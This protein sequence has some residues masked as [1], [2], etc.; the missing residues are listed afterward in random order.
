MTPR[1]TIRRF[2][3]GVGSLAACLAVSLPLVAAEPIAWGEDGYAQSGDVRIHYVSGGAGPLVV[4]LHGFPDCWYTWRH[5]APA[6]A[7]SFQVVAIDQRGYNLSDQPEGVEQYS[8][9]RLVADVRAV[10]QHFGRDQA[11]IVGHDWGGAVAWAFA[12]AHPEMTDRLVILNLPHPH[13]LARELA[14]NEQQR[15]N[16]QYARSFQEPGAEDRLT[17]E[18][19]AA[20]VD[21][22]NDRAVYIAAFRRSSFA[23]M[24]NFYRANYPRPPYQI[25]STEPP[26]VA[27]PVLMIHGLDD[28]ALLPGALND[29]WR[30]IDAEFTLVTIPHA[31]H[32]VQHDAA[33][34]VTR[35]MASWLAEELN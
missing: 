16:S 11:V 2:A 1:K 4:M 23:G 6:L 13:G 29:T 35:K 8:M 33:E 14:T 30:W 7:K 22:E 18:G 3:V 32:F 17:A 24:L 10:I 20:W 27:C 15:K 31:G 21:D 25:P 34:Q 19:L 28:Q 5:Q 26:P 12:M 9:D